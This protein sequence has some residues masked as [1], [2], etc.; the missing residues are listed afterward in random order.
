MDLLLIIKA[1]VITQALL[2]PFRM[3]LSPSDSLMFLSSFKLV[4]FNKGSSCGIVLKTAWWDFIYTFKI[5]IIF[6][7]KSTSPTFGNHELYINLAQSP[8]SVQTLSHPILPSQVQKWT[9]SW[10]KN[11]IGR[12][13]TKRSDWPTVWS[14][15]KKTFWE[16]TYFFF[17]KTKREKETKEKMLLGYYKEN[18][19]SQEV[20]VAFWE[21]GS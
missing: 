18:E 13:R 21:I 17:L 8:G 20:K 14:L 11:R 7:M 3:C 10:V 9:E 4:Y 6:K 15:K 2:L 12:T 5:K 1:E 19:T 16:G